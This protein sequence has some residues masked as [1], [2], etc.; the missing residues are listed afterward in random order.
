MLPNRIFAS[1]GNAMCTQCYTYIELLWA[2][3]IFKQ[4]LN[5]NKEN[6][7]RKT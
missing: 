5:K 6:G 1:R 4:K 7:F 3:Q 2:N